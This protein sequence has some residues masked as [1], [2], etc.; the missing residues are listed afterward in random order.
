M[1]GLTDGVGEQGDGL[2]VP[3]G[4]G[5]VLGDLGGEET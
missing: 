5:D 4:E 1:L 2:L 3:V